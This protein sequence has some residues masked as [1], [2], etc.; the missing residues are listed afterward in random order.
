MRN[1]FN[2]ILVT[3]GAGFIGS[4]LTEKLAERGYRI[5]VLDNMMT[6]KVQNLSKVLD[7]IKLVKGDIRDNAVIE[8]A[9]K[10]V[11]VIV[12]LAALVSVQESMEKPLLYHEVNSLGTMNLLMHAAKAG[13]RKFIFISSCAVY[14]DPKMVPISEEHPTKPLSPYAQDKLEAEE[15]CRAYSRMGKVNATILRLFNVY[16][17]RQNVNQY[18]S[19]ITQ[20]S[21][22]LSKNMRPLIYGG[23]QTRDFIYVDDVTEYIM[24][25]IEDDVQDTFNIGTG[26]NMS[27]DNLARLMAKI[28][29]KPHLTPLYMPLKPGDI[30]DSVADIS[31][32]VRMLKYVPKTSIEEG[33]SKTFSAIQTK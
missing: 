7:R 26:K 15:H 29:G 24:R 27:I 20:F 32:A 17:P 31:K 9:V 3:G 4:H 10:D 19:V 25:A 13:A 23:S 1:K 12:H 21:D 8:E 22:R 11:E 2:Q 28:A 18:S 14:G 6:G 33:L 16:G 30:R 5:T